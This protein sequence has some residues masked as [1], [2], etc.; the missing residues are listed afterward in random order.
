MLAVDRFVEFA[1]GARSSSLLVSI[2]NL[3]A[4]RF[5]RLHLP[6]T[7]PAA[8]PVLVTFILLVT[9]IFILFVSVVT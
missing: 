8:C 3:R 1:K 4:L 6:L 2:G 5:G 7:Q 9:V